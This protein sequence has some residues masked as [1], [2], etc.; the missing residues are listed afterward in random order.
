[1]LLGTE[2]NGFVKS[3]DG[4]LTW[5]RLRAGLRSEVTNSYPEVWDIA[6]SPSNPDIVMAATL[7]SPVPTTGDF[8]S[9]N[10]GIY[11]STDG[12]QT[13]RQLNCGFTTSRVNSVR[14]HPTD[15]DSAIAGLESGQA[16]YSV[17]GVQGGFFEGGIFRTADGGES[18][19][20]IALGPN[21]GRSGFWVMRQVPTDPLALITFA[22]N[23]DD[24]SENIGFIRSTDN[25]LTWQPFAEE[26][27][28]KRIAS[29]TV[30]SDG[31]VFYANEDRTYFGWVSR[32]GG[33]T[34]SQSALHQVNGPVAVSPVDANLVLFSSQ[35]ELRRSTNGLVTVQVV[36]TSIPHNNG[37]SPSPFREIQFAPSDPSIVYAEADGYLLYRSDDAGASW[38]LVANVRADVLNAQP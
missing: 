14:I 29:F 23:Y 16:S 13:W 20:R 4:G 38:R 21:D 31:Q 35:G 28:A 15:S 5:T 37:D 19:Q 7:D 33:A 11:R 18:W 36:G 34:W 6:F 25:G 26:L 12:G 9:I 24:P 30:S 1:M 2:R 22:S 17:N 10:G 8:P 27:R 3:T 32:D